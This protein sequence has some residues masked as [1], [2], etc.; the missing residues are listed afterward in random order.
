MCKHDNG[1]HGLRLFRPK[2]VT[3]AAQITYYC[4][5]CARDKYGHQMG[6]IC[7]IL[8]M[9]IWAIYVQEHN[10][11]EKPFSKEQCPHISTDH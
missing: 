11:Y 9:H 5:I 10:T 6:H 4:Q 1:E 7:Q 8:N 3:S 2:N